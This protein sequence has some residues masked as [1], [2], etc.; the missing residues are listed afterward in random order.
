MKLKM[1]TVAALVLAAGSVVSAAP[2]TWSGGGADANWMTPGNWVGGVAPQAGDSLIFDGSVQVGNNNNFPV[3]TNFAGITVAATSASPTLGGNSIN[4]SG[5]L[6]QNRG[7]TATMNT[8]FVLQNDVNF[9]VPGA[10]ATLT[11][12]GIVSGPSKVTKTGPGLLVYNVGM[13]YAGGTDVTGGTLR[14]GNSGNTSLALGTGTISISNGALVELRSTT[15]TTFNNALDLGTGGGFISIRSNHTLSPTA[16][17]GTGTLNLTAS[18]TNLVF[19]ATDF[20]NWNGT[21]STSITSG[22]S[23]GIRQANAYNNASMINAVLNLGAGTFL[24]KQNGTNTTNVV[25]DIGTLKGD[26]GSSVGGSAAGTGYFTYSVGSRNEDSTFAGNVNDGSTKT[27]LRK[28]GTGTLTLSG[29]AN[30]MSGPSAVNAGTLLVNG[31]LTSAALV[32]TVGASGTLGGNGSIAGTVSFAGGTMTPGALVNSV[33]TLT[34]SGPTSFAAA[35]QL[36]YGLNGIDTSIGGIVND[37]LTGV[38]DLTLNGSVNISETVAGSFA[39]AATPSSWRLINYT[40][41]LTDNG[42]V[43]GTVP[44]IPAGTALALD[45]STPGQ[46][47][48]TLT[49]IPEP[50][51][52]ALAA[53]AVP[54]LVRR[55]R[56]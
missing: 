18:V 22:Q 6:N 47:N 3:G 33:G 29:T 35:S 15:A 12:G 36:N 2:L 34:I 42:L 48:L 28:V 13:T 23:F 32:E 14:M 39:S 8:P 54:V 55:R 37:L 51:G 50:S 5:D 20:K 38:T 19:T 11:L 26:A 10:G 40:G 17:T 56:R 25:V 44:A 53:M 49:A 9:A 41:T 4:L 52:L 24:S 1:M 21:I 31:A 45:Y 16:I 27:A 7:T 43:L 30:T 46:V